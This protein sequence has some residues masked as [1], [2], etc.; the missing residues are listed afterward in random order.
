MALY[1]DLLAVFDKYNVGIPPHLA[2]QLYALNVALPPTS[3]LPAGCKLANIVG[4]PGLVYLTGLTGHWGKQAY[5]I[6]EV[7]DTFPSGSDE[8]NFVKANV[9][10]ANGTYMTGQFIPACKPLQDSLPPQVNGKE[11]AYVGTVAC[12][13]DNRGT[14]FLK[15]VAE[16][17]AHFS[18]L[19]EPT[20]GGDFPHP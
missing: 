14:E 17:F 4:C 3:S 10:Y 11:T 7:G 15:T 19:A 20:T 5:A 13:P 6:D 1:D 8:Y 2:V 12:P 16:A 9:S 18:A